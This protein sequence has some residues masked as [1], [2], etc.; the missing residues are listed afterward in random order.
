MQKFSNLIILFT[1]LIA[2]MFIYKRLE[3]KRIREED[4]EDYENIRKYLLND[5][6]GNSTKPI[7]WIHIPYEYNSR[8]WMSFGSR[9]FFELN[10]PYLYLII[11]SII[12]K[13]DESFKICLIDDTSFA[14]LIPEWNINLMSIS[15]PIL[16]NVR[17][18]AMMKLLYIYGGMICPC[19]FLC[20]RNLLGMYH[21][22]G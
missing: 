20:M 4:V 7:L 6:L 10:Q 22:C 14:K 2:V 3:D 19:S 5:D 13:C 18:L 16:T 15:Q 9:S 21:P 8:N 17:Q 12:M 1:I 11:K